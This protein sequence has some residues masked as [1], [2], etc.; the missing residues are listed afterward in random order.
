MRV[1]ISGTPGSGTTTIAAAVAER[2]GLV[3]LNAGERFRQL[4]ERRGI[5]VDDLNR[6]AEEREPLDRE[7]HRRIVAEAEAL[8]DVLLESRYSSRSL[9]DVDVRVWLDAPMAVRARRVADREGVTVEEARDRIADRERS[10]RE[11]A[12]RYYGFDV[13]DRSIYDVRLNTGRLDV[14]DSIALLADI[15]ETHRRERSEESVVL[16]D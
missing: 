14:A 5:S 8:D 6:R 2:L 16:A 15:V 7:F 12:E 9:D 3:H 1:T 4:A 10:V 13:D 11:R